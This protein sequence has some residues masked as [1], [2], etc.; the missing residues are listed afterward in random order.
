MNTV[1]NNDKSQPDWLYPSNTHLTAQ[2]CAL[3]HSAHNTQLYSRDLQLL[4][5][6]ICFILSA[7][8]LFICRKR[9]MRSNMSTTTKICIKY[10][11]SFER[12]RAQYIV[13]ILISV[14]Y[15]HISLNYISGDR[16]NSTPLSCWKRIQPTMNVNCL[17]LIG[18]K[19]KCS[20]CFVCLRLKVK[21]TLGFLWRLYFE[22]RL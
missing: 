6:L 7:I 16:I 19:R 9:S 15:A 14:T 3:E 8:C 11:L 20:L 17:W 22:V 1:N 18:S 10:W 21:I 12:R 4:S 2:Y 5:A 13:H